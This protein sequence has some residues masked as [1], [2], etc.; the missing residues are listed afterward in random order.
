MRNTSHKLDKSQ[1]TDNAIELIKC[2]RLAWKGQCII[3]NLDFYIS[4]YINQLD[5]LKKWMQVN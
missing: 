1:G 4:C 5:L 2:I 3:T